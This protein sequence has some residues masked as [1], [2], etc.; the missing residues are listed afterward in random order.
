MFNEGLR[1]TKAGRYQEAIPYYSLHR[2]RLGTRIQSGDLT[3]IAATKVHISNKPIT[4]YVLYKFFTAIL[5]SAKYSH[6]SE[7]PRDAGHASLYSLA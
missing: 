4:K 7:H 3:E 5:L 6:G 1:L 2:R